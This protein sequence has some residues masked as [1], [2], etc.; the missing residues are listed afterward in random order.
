MSELALMTATEAKTRIAAGS[1]TAAAYREACLDRIAKLEPT[2]NAFAH[3]DAASVHSAQPRQGALAGLPFGVKDVLD[4]AY[5]PA[6]YGSPIWK[7]FQPRAD[8]ACVALACAAGGVVMGKT[9]TTEFATRK[10]GPTAN[11]HNPGHTPG[12]SSSG[13]AAGVAAGFFPF[14]F[15]TQTAGSIIR[16]AAYCGVVGYK[17]TYSTI[18][19][20]GMKLMSESLDTIGTMARSVEDCAMLASAAGAGDLGD[21]SRHPTSLPRIGLCPGPNAITATDDALG[22]LAR[23]ASA[24]AK[25]GASV[26]DAKLPAAFN[27]LDQIQPLVMNGESVLS[28]GWELTHHAA[29]ISPGLRERLAWGAEQGSV[30]LQQGRLAMFDAQARFDAF[31]SDFDILLTQSAPGEAPE[32]LG[33]TGEPSFNAVWTALGVP[34]VTLPYGTGSKGLPLG[35]QIV[36]RRGQ[37]AV[38]LAWAALVAKLLG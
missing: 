8:A 32:G 25:A 19:R 35:V 21:P 12:G 28:M 26:R 3:F 4:T 29:G 10:P 5:M 14:G 9:V 20:L 30:A 18:P 15:G 23:A 2:I 17:P 13:T 27:A 31:I 6:Q 24:L 37:D 36:G 33:N 1:L 7:G 11:P 34:C 22:N 16:P 38:V